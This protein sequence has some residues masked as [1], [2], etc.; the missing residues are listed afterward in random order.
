PAPAAPAPAP[1][2]PAPAPAAP[3]PAST[4]LSSTASASV[5]STPTT[6]T[7]TSPAV[8]ASSVPLASPSGA[9]AETLAASAAASAEL[10]ED[11]SD[12]LEHKLGVNS[13]SVGAT[14]RGASHRRSG[15][16]NQDSLK[17]E[18]SPGEETG[19]MS[20][21]DG[22]GDARCFRSD[23]G[24]DIATTV[25]EDIGSQF[26]ATLPDGLDRQGL[27]DAALAYLPG[28]VLAEWKSRVEADLASK[29]ITETEI[30]SIPSAGAARAEVQA[31]P[32]LA[33][34]STLV[35]AIATKEH[36]LL[37]QIGDGDIV[38]VNAD[39]TVN[40][41]ITNPELM[42]NQTTSLSNNNPTQFKVAVIDRSG[43][44]PALVMVSTDGLANSNRGSTEFH[45]FATDIHKLIQT[46]QGEV[47]K[48]NMT[49]WLRDA[50]QNGS[51]DDITMGIVALF[52]TTPVNAAEVAAVSSPDTG[53][54]LGTPAVT[55]TQ[56]AS[57]VVPEVRARQVVEITPRRKGELLRDVNN[58]LRSSSENELALALRPTD[59]A[60]QVESMQGVPGV[61]LKDLH[62]EIAGE[63]SVVL[64]GHADS[65]PRFRSTIGGELRVDE[66]N[67]LVLV[68][69]P[70]LDLSS[71]HI[72]FKGLIRSKIADL[73]NSVKGKLNKE[74]VSAWEVTGFGIDPI[75]GRIHV[76][77]HRK[78]TTA[79]PPPTPPPQTPPSGGGG[80]PGSPP[81]PNTSADAQELAA[82][83]RLAAQAADIVSSLRPARTVAA[84][85]QLASPPVDDARPVETAVST[86]QPSRM[87]DLVTFT[88]RGEVTPEQQARLEA[89]L[90]VP[91]HIAGEGGRRT[92]QVGAVG[93]S[94][95]RF[96]E[97]T[98]DQ[99]IAE[100]G[101]KVGVLVVDSGVPL[102]DWAIPPPVSI[103]PV[104]DVALAIEQP[105]VPI[106]PAVAVPAGTFDD[107]ME[108]SQPVVIELSETSPSPT[109][110]QLRETEDWV[111]QTQQGSSRLRAFEAAGQTQEKQE[112][113][114]EM[115][116][117][118][119][120]QRAAITARFGDGDALELLDPAPIQGVDWDFQTNPGGMWSCYLASADNALRM[121]GKSSPNN[122]EQAFSRAL[123]PDYITS[124]PIGAASGDVKRL[125]EESTPGV[126]VDFSADVADILEATRAGAVA[127]IPLNSGHVGVIPPGNQLYGST[128]VPLE[129][130]VI[131]PNGRG[132]RWMDVDQ[133]VKS[134]IILA[135][136][137]G[138]FTPNSMALLIYALPDIEVGEAEDVAAEPPTSG[139]DSPSAPNEGEKPID[140]DQ[141]MSEIS[142]DNKARVE[143]GLVEIRR[144]RAAQGDNFNPYA[145]DVIALVSKVSSDAKRAFIQTE[146]GQEQERAL[147]EKLASLV[148]GV[149]LYQEFVPEQ[150]ALM[151]ELLSQIPGASEL[152]DRAQASGD[153]SQ[154]EEE[155]AAVNL[156]QELLV[157]HY[158]ISNRD[159]V[160]IS[161]DEQNVAG[162]IRYRSV[163]E[164][165]PV[166][167]VINATILYAQATNAALIARD[168]YRASLRGALAETAEQ[169]GLR[170]VDGG[171]AYARLERIPPES[172]VQPPD[173]SGPDQPT[174]PAEPPE[175]EL[176]T[177]TVQS[178]APVRTL[179][180]SRLRS[181][182]QTVGRRAGQ[183]RNSLDKAR[184][185]AGQAKGKLGGLAG[186]AASLAR[187]RF[188]RTQET[189]PPTENILDSAEAEGAMENSSDPEEAVPS[190]PG[191]DTGRRQRN[192]VELTPESVVAKV[193]NELHLDIR[194]KRI[195]QVGFNN[196]LNNQIYADVRQNQETNT[197]MDRS[198]L[199][200]VFQGI[201][202]IWTVMPQLRVDSSRKKAVYKHLN[203][204]VWKG[205]RS[206]PKQE[207]QGIA[208][209][210]VKIMSV[211]ASARDRFPDMME[212]V[213]RVGNR[214]YTPGREL[215]GELFAVL[216]SIKIIRDSV[217]GDYL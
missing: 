6:P 32:T 150:R 20:V 54:P 74:V 187:N 70:T 44:D 94:D 216:S 23:V 172:P 34:G 123:G 42:A 197:V 125:I 153:G 162:G 25:F 79:Q 69:E 198:R 55:E 51:G 57:V 177:E 151:R 87:G 170:I 159:Q 195:L 59:L 72:V 116:R 100:L 117:R 114:A 204:T 9:P 8:T 156:L 215:N 43:G 2:A 112:Y 62:L 13:E 129:V 148:K 12:R 33:Y 76:L 164:G 166:A 183:A 65:F 52:P 29:P 77:V 138:D 119:D 56:V 140:I 99:V 103:E 157:S 171:G 194:S 206:L 174:S 78:G 167:E 152:Y 211:P 122:R 110:E 213:Q 48:Q 71:A 202:D 30:D 201:G 17:I 158:N 134:D 67:Q 131:D 105:A 81:P 145:E 58:I 47:V 95:P 41:P 66:N 207:K 209:D 165:H 217:R 189:L 21:A 180:R 18:Y 144:L 39:G 93:P 135:G 82:A 154:T 53:V 26:L 98:R 88:L 31:N 121:I 86:E 102:P 63:D 141:V 142:G 173:G 212:Y 75:A 196:Y 35:G 73:N 91:V 128:G 132:M 106:Q 64:A 208:E 155:V 133:L 214:D 5:T 175:P 85:T 169:I 203:D 184:D 124:H 101:R 27:Q 104:S 49:R 200:E 136:R 83:T 149:N 50:T 188:G 84:A 186:R 16:P 36:L 160:D 97:R 11:P 176:A 130:R 111:S 40:T 137:S 96:R 146:L 24:S 182:A 107:R 210:L 168:S 113:L 163:V 28:A 1:A 14:V 4:P 185:L 61:T 90:G 37:V 193:S 181:L 205:N 108:Y 68:G 60:Q 139:P 118:V 89:S 190:A 92:L 179:G 45:E 46:G 10:A 147:S 127:I 192:R 15:L 199:Q 115:Y 19:I 161:E 80:G 38:I 143:E 3:A 7:T 178:V 126:K 22:H 191:L 120:Q 109:A